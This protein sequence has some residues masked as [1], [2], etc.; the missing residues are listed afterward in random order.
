MK[1]IFSILFFTIIFNHCFSQVYTINQGGTIT[2]C[3][4][5]FYDSGNSGANYGNNENFTMTFHSSN[6]TN[7]HIRV[8]FS[9]FGVDASDTLY[10]YDGSS[11]AAPLLGKYNNAMPVPSFVMA[12][13]YNASGDLTFNFKSDATINTS[14]WFASI[15]CSKPCQKIIANLSF[16]ETF[17]TPDSNYVDICLGNG[18]TFAA[19]A[20]N[21][22]FPENGVL[23]TQDEAT[24]QFLWDF[25]DGQTATGR[26]VNHLYSQVR[27]YD[28]GL[29][30]TDA[31]GCVNSNYLG[32]RV[33]VSSNPYGQISPIPD[34]CSGSDTTYVS[35]GYNSGSVITINP[36]TSVQSS[37]QIFD[38]TMFIPDGPACAVQCYNTY[39]TFTAF[40]PSSTVQSASDIMGICVNMEHSYAGD[41]GFRIICPNGQSV[42]LDPNT[43]SG[44]AFMGIPLE[45][46]A[47]DLNHQ[48]D[49]AYNTPGT[50]WTYCW[51]EIYPTH[52]TL[53]A[54][55]SGGFGGAIDSTNTVNHTNYIQPNNPLSGL[56]GCPLNGTWNIEICDDFG[57]DNGY[58]FWWSLQ[59]DPSL[60]PVNWSYQVPIDSIIWT[61]N[62]FTNV[63]DSVIMIVPDSSGSFQYTVRLVDKFGCSYDTTFNLQVVQTPEVN[64]GNDTTVCSNGF[65]MDLD[66]GPGN[67]YTWNNGY[68]QQI[69]SITSSGTYSVTVTNI[70]AA[71]T[72][73]CTS[74]DTIEIKSLVLPTINLGPDICS[75]TPVTLDAGNPSLLHQWSDGATT[76]THT[77]TTSGTYSCAVAEQFG[78][79]CEVNDEVVITIIPEPIIDAGDNQT[80]CRHT[81]V[82]IALTDPNNYLS[83]YTYNY[84]WTFNPPIDGGEISDLTKG[85][86]SL[87]WLTPGVY[88]ITGKVTGCTTVEDKMFLTIQPCDLEMPNVITPN[89]DGVNDYLRIPNVEF[90]PNSTM[91]IFNRWGEKVY[92]NTNYNNEWNGENCADGVYFY[93]FDVNY[94][95]HKNGID[96]R[97]L[98]GVVN[99]MR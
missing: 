31:N 67:L 58:I 27:G 34:L 32:A 12:S 21:V 84:S 8:N 33:R 15:V 25:G 24:S 48:C 30:I 92:E 79:G 83:N 69:Y 6:P 26:V 73:Q 71:Q 55:S 43:H 37:T 90:Y 19:L 36:I 88:E 98:N 81:N 22:A 54:L 95:S 47:D 64:L 35:V 60:L 74:R 44:G 28:I 51:S 89:G 80:A 1:N 94:G 49:G 50:G 56:I 82:F 77:I 96:L 38:S 11:T 76:Q 75:T 41:L 99:I 86:I 20:N 91:R 72:L 9:T 68:D 29:T 39:V 13:I 5:D 4:A 17:P 53:D 45:G 65:Q 46:L 2:G 14:G 52:G 70:N 7:T 57:Q 61:G 93:I 10:V 85:A 63:S 40:P 18:I 78:Y 42:Q 87:S 23:Y 62:A 66:A 16:P 97:P 3:A 59:L